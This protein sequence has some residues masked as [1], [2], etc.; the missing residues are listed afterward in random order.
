MK[1]D[2]HLIWFLAL[3]ALLALFVVMITFI[4]TET[5]DHPS[6]MKNVILQMTSTLENSDTQL[7]FNYAE[8]LGDERGITFG[9]VGFCTGTYDG[10]ILIKHYTELNPDN[11]LAKYIPVLDKI[12]TDSHDV[13]DGD[14]NPSTEGLDGFIE[15]VQNCDDPLF[16]KAQMD[17]VDEFYYNPAME[18]ADSIGAKNALTK[19]FIYDMCVRHGVDQTEGI[20]KDA[21][22][23][24]KQGADENTYLWE[25]I[26]LRDEKLKQENI[27]DVNRN[28]GYKNILNSG[29]VDLK[30]PFTFVAYGDHF[31]IDGNLNL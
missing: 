2:K 13:A 30:T 17:K 14:G 10:N 11:T 21:G 22:T 29:N 12:D 1:I 31:T 4:P 18:I 27:G 9:C 5:T 28:Q 16:K 23:T 6:N 8:N 26:S 7:Q 3:L 15:D 19:A 25:L 20:I 24:P